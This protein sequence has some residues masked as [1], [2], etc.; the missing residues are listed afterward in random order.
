MSVIAIVVI[1]V[2]VA[3][4]LLGLFFLLPRFRERAR[5][6][7]RDIELRQRRERVI[8]EHQEEA[9]RRERDAEIA[10]RRAGIA[11]QEAQR[12][13]AEARLR[14]EKAALHEQ[15]MA[16]NELVE[17][18]E[19]E[20]FAG[21]SAAPESSVDEDRQHSSAYEEGRRPAQD[22]SREEEFQAGRRSERR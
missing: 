5:V 21:T 1:V 2:V 15:G 4:V 3:V 11:E 19:R 13:R 20:D 14:R 12:E 22:P 7:K 6:K 17:D 10:E 9:E 18:H 16:D 8:G